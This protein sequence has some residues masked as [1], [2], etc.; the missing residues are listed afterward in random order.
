MKTG[1]FI[2]LVFAAFAISASAAKPLVIAHRGH[3]NAEG[4]AQNSI[5]ALVKA[6]SIGADY[7]EFDVW[8]T[9][10]SVL[11]VNHDST[12]RGVDIEHSP[13]AEV[14]ALKLD[15]GENLPTLEQYLT[16]AKDLDL[17]LICEIKTHD[18]NDTEREC[19]RR[20]LKMV[21]DFGLQDRTE[22]VMFSKNGLLSLMEYAPE[23]VRT[24]YPRGDYLPE[25]VKFMG[26]SGITYKIDVL[27]KHPDWI[28]RCHDLGLTVNIWT[29]TTPEDMQWCIDQGADYITCNDPEG[30]IA[31]L[32]K[33]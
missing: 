11:V 19:I 3:F 28:K 29:I 22:Y 13:S 20:T 26:I 27:R 15:N 31:L 25:Q 24:Q 8:M 16:A 33:K 18:S 32:N 9:A 2:A 7:S 12:F 14:C 5:R 4:S 10:D 23:G 21:N 6:D 1:K 17:K 30:L